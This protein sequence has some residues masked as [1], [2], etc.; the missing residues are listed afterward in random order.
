ME[1]TF[2]LSVPQGDRTGGPECLHQLADAIIRR[3]YRARLVP[4]HN[5][6]GCV[7]DPEY[8]VY[9]YEL[10]D[11]IEDPDNAIL[12]IGEVSPIES[13][14]EL[15]QIS[16]QRTWL[17]WLSV[18]NGPDPRSRY[19]QGSDACCTFA[20]RPDGMP[21]DALGAPDPAHPPIHVTPWGDATTSG[22]LKEAWKRSHA[23]YRAKPGLRSFAVESASLLFNRRLI[24]S[25]IGFLAQSVYAQG[26][27]RTV[28]GREALP[29]TDYLRR[30]NI[31]PQQRKQRTIAYN[32]IKGYTKIFELQ[33]LLPDVQFVPIKG[34]S[35]QQVCETLASSQI[36]V[37]LGLPPGRDRLPREAAHFG[38]AVAL[39]CRGT[40]YCWDD[41]PL[42]PRYRVADKPGW[43]AQL[44]Q[45]L[46]FMLDNPEQV[47]NDQEFFRTWVTGD[48]DRYESEVDSWLA[49]ALA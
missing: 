2:Y 21:K 12:V 32:A 33:S 49:R 46:L 19:F 9:E 27:C 25:N 20:P 47:R 29:M 38:A 36:Y 6:R 13:W 16:A 30:P 48:R 44:A 11:R 1:P 35:Y 43:A 3:G 17:W 45:T 31:A 14:R 40:A 37:E 15:R 7:P 4:M 8:D 18:H 22:L 5:F 41:F 10:A 24:E 23:D 28:L 34:M 39:L 42:P 26:F